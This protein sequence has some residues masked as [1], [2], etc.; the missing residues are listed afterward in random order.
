MAGDLSHSIPLHSAAV[1]RLAVRVQGQGIGDV[2]DVAL[3]CTAGVA[4][5]S[6]IGWWR[7]PRCRSDSV[8]GAQVLNAAL[9]TG[10]STAEIV[11]AVKQ[12]SML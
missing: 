10:A 8:A 9:T 5:L 4:S 12:S 2:P 7:W 3:A 6:S 1:Q 11:P